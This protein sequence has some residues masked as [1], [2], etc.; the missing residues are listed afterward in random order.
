M[1]FNT[2]QHYIKHALDIIFPRACLGCSLRGESL[3]AE[4]ARNLP[5]NLRDSDS[6]DDIEALWNYGDPLVKK[7]IWSLKY[8]GDRNIAQLC[9]ISLY[10]RIID[11]L[12][13]NILFENAGT[14]FLIPIPASRA[15][16]RKRGFNQT[17]LLTKEIELLD[18]GTMFTV[19]TRVL[20]KIIDVPSQTSIKERGKRLKNIQGCFAVMRPELIHGKHIILID[21]VYT[22]SGTLQEAKKV[23]EKA[24]AKKVIAFT[25][26]H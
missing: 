18:S 13:E 3:C 23:L 22:T 26:A 25:L 9:G 7:V 1:N 5:Q 19:N 24:G 4:C 11:S 16:L 20:K 8:K 10:E 21:D 2:I 15:R 14:Y 6:P 12:G 17:E